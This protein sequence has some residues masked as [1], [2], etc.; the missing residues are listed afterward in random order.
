ML[1][2]GIL[3]CFS[4]AASAEGDAAVPE[5][6]RFGAL[7]TLS[8]K[9][10][11]A[12]ED[13]RRGI[14]A[15]LTAARARHR[16]HAVYADSRNDPTAAISEFRKLIEADKVLAVY[17]HRSSMGMTLNPVSFKAGVPLLGAVGNRDF[18]GGNPYAVQVWPKS[19]DEGHFLAAKLIEKGLK[20]AALVYTEDEWTTP[21]AAAFREKFLQLGGTLVFDQAALPSETDFR[22]QLLQ[23]KS[24][25]PDAFY[26]NMLLPQLAPI[27][28][29]AREV[30]LHAAIF[31]NFYIAKQEIVDALG[32]TAL[33]GI[34]Y[35]ELDTE[36][37]ALKAHLGENEA[38]SPPGL[39]VASYVATLLLAQAASDKKPLHT[40]A[41]LQAELLQQH[42]VRTPDYVYP[43]EN[44]CVK[45]PLVLKVIR[46]HTR[47]LESSPPRH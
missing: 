47:G 18:A 30:A 15:G 42:E 10:A 33:A 16:L 32:H 45:F 38:F 28:K 35:I 21:V 37:P 4:T 19:D 17:T 27:V 31:S 1:S 23:I 36:L 11:S 41:D 40:P 46:S 7:L 29:Q 6:S 43:I 3:V 20:R 24:K 13:C 9:F 25:S 2:I 44:R 22:T 39:T 5:T 26:A 12:G 34:S 14:E 8:G